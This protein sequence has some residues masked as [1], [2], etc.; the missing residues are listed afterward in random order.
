MG[1]A[2]FLVL[3]LWHGAREGNSGLG[4]P[5]L[6]VQPMPSV[7]ACEAVG[8]AAKEM[9]DGQRPY[10]TASFTLDN[11]WQP[12]YRTSYSLPAVYRCVEVPR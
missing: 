4:G 6:L 1:K 3:Y 9:A 10:P 2:V 12:L 7:A 5:Q 11:G 8:R